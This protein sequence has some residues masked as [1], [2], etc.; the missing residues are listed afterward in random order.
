MHVIKG[1][2]RAG[3]LWSNNLYTIHG[4][5][6]VRSCLHSNDSCMCRQNCIK[7]EIIL[8]YIK[9]TLKLLHG[10]N[11]HMHNCHKAPPPSPPTP[12][13]KIISTPL[14]MISP[15]LAIERSEPSSLIL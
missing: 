13:L 5:V 3:T 9:Y 14:V 1:V 12:T 6:K 8:L 7:I 4:I 11:C 10:H 2:N 15:Y